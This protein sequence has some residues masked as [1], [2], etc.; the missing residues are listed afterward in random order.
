MARQ[1]RPAFPAPQPPVALAV[2]LSDAQRQLEDRIKL[3]REIRGSLSV[4]PV[5]TID[6]LFPKR[7]EA[8]YRRD[9]QKWKEYNS[10]LL[11]KIFSTNAIE[12][13]YDTA[14]FGMTL[15]SGSNGD[16]QLFSDNVDDQIDKLESILERLPLY[17]EPHA[18]G[19]Q[20]EQ[21]RD[22]SKVFVVHGHDG[23]SRLAIARFI[24]QIGFEAI[25]LHERPNKGRTII[26][27]FRE[28]AADVGFA[29]VLMT[30][31]DLGKPNNDSEAKFRA[32]QNVVFELG[33]FIGALG[34]ERVAALIKGDIE[35]PSD[36]DGVV[37]IS[38]DNGGWKTELGRELEAAGYGIDWNKVMRA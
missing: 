23:E 28:E 25:I 10:A 6:P 19:M 31:D 37:Y 4:A 34:P 32:R 2:A 21:R 8:T 29:V 26:T 5:M 20:Q 12:R 13:E 35:R 22:L 9:A 17:S 16:L 1:P 30:P 15:N 38:L 33:F 14:T 7:D 18:P 24:E 27:K 11:K 36:F 3:G